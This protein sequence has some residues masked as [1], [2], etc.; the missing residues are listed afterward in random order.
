MAGAMLILLSA[1]ATP[2]EVKQLSTAQIQYFDTAIQAVA[3]QSEALVL[4]S[5]KIQKQ[6]EER[7]AKRE[8]DSNA[9]LV[10]LLSDSNKGD[11]TD[12]RKSLAEKVLTA[13]KSS[14]KSAADARAKLQQDLDA[15]KAK[16]EELGRYIATM[17]DVQIALDAY[18]QSEKAGEKI[19]SSVLGQPSVSHLIDKV[20][21][22]IPN[23]TGAANDLK[24][25]LS[26]LGG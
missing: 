2:P 20:Q 15:I 25:L 6:A 12:E 22:T 16:S 21:K 17:K 19:V 7:I 3:T 23:V 13:S 1:C 24:L 18:I 5:T 14:A 10:K 8:A 11:S 4:A 26:G 9:Q